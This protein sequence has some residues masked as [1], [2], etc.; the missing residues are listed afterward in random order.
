MISKSLPSFPTLVQAST[1]T[2]AS[3]PAHAG[4]ATVMT[5]ITSSC[6]YIPAQGASEARATSGWGCW[7]RCCNGAP[8]REWASPEGRTRCGEEAVGRAKQARYEIDMKGT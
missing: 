8:V 7:N 6:G 3:I 1:H 5:L 2:V 4:D